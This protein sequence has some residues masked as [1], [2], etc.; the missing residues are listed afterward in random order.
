LIETNTLL[1]KV[2]IP[3]NLDRAWR[4]L[5]KSNSSSHGLSLETVEQ[6]SRNST[7]NLKKIRKQLRTD[8]FKFSG[9]RAVVIPEK[10][11]SGEIKRRPIRV[12][13]VRDR[14]VQRAVVNIIEP[15]LNQK[16]NL[17]NDVSFAYLKDRDVRRAMLRVIGL[18][19][20]GNPIVLEVDIKDFFG[21][22]N[23]DKLLEEMV[24]P[25]LP[26]G[27]LNEMIKNALNQEVGNLVETDSD[28]ELFP[29]CGIPQGGGL[30]PLFANVYLHGFD[31]E[32]VE[33]G[34]G[35]VRYADDFVVMCKDE[36]EARHAYEKAVD[37]LEGK[38]G[39]SL[40]KLDEENS[41]HDFF[42]ISKI[43][44]SSF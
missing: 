15:Y 12:P 22:V 24:Y 30:S 41:K 13:E 9:I 4:E 35:L 37:I 26:D 25:Q 20:K 39:L 21:S 10:K 40:H 23:R 38:L 7:S 8:E 33:N 44:S 43:A 14:V 32:M 34:F 29:D 5:N 36:D 17:R 19:R 2:Q 16:F 18:H 11:P 3:R 6:F 28:W 1:H 31:R 27:T 42:F